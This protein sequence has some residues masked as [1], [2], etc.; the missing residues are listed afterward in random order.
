M[1]A[2]LIVASFSL[3]FFCL[4]AP[5]GERW[6]ETLRRIGMVFCGFVAVVSIYA[7]VNSQQINVEES[8][9]TLESHDVVAVRKA[10]SNQYT[11][12]L[13]QDDG[14]VKEAQ[15]PASQ[16]EV[17]PDATDEAWIEKVEVSTKWEEHYDLFI[18]QWDEPKR[19]T[20][21]E[22]RLHISHD[23]TYEVL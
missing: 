4:M 12:L 10:S 6:Q 16:T 1:L 3:G 19:D 20:R 17:Y 9:T 18:L 2:I 5:Y 7:W 15:Y 13:P 8:V 14:S 11:V 21:E 23:S 22:Y